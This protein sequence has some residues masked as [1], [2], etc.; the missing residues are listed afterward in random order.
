MTK[1]VALLAA[2]LSIALLAA[3]GEDG[4]EPGAPREAT[5][6]LDFQPNAVHSGIYT[7]LLRGY[8]DEQGVELS[9]REPSASADAPKLLEAGRAEA[10]ILDIH[11][12]GLARE[13]GFDVVG[14]AAIVQRPLAAVIARDRDE[15]HDPSDLAGAKV[16]VTGLPSD[17]AVLDSVL[18]TS[19]VA[20]DA[21]ERVTIGFKAVS[22]LSAGRLDAATAFWN[23]EGV[24]LR[25]LGL[26]TR[27]LRVDDYGAPHY[28]ELV[29]AVDRT[30]LEEERELVRAIAAAT[31]RG[32]SDVLDDADAAL[33][34]LLEQAPGLEAVEQ[35]AQMRALMEA[36]AFE[37]A[38]TLDRR[39]LEEWGSW[40]VEHG[41][42]ESAPDIDRAFAL[43]LLPAEGEDSD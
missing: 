42:L 14:V 31:A 19:G 27:E 13:R 23:A 11:D 33:S 3:C 2:V 15:V 25:R 20:P 18:E 17:D 5:V 29:L 30:T 9:V 12:L 1:V 21:V 8:Y 24:M 43:D 34:D 6:V 36:D 28:P 39:A 26:E 4:A 16:G 10:A 40:D 37:P 22:A 41:I 32:Y 38:A 7:A 35:R